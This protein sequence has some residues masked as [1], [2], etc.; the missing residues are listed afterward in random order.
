MALFDDIGG[1]SGLADRGPSVLIFGTL[2]FLLGSGFLFLVSFGRWR[3]RHWP[4]YSEDRR[5][6]LEPTR[7][8][9][10]RKSYF[11]A[12][13]A[14]FIGFVLLLIVGFFIGLVVGIA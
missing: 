10:G 13:V 3:V 2:C 5:M 14:M 11:C 1:S 4:T 7:V 9:V 6:P 12:D 8:R